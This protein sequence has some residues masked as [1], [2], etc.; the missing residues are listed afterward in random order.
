MRNAAIG[1]EGFFAGEAT[2]DELV[3]DNKMARG[4][5]GLQAAHRGEGDQVGDADAFQGV[6]IGAVIQA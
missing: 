5:L 3:D 2:V 1:E 4:Q 6:N